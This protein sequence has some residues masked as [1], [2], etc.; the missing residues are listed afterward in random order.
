MRRLHGTEHLRR[1]RAGSRVQC[2]IVFEEQSNSFLPRLGGCVQQLL[3]D[4]GTVG[5]GIIQPPEIKAAQAFCAKGF[6]HFNSAFQDF[7]LLGEREIRFEIVRFAVL[8]AR[9][10]GPV[11]LKQRTRD[12]GDAQLV[13]FENALR[14]LNLRGIQVHDVLVPHTTQLDPLHTKL[15]GGHFAGTAEILGNLVVDYADPEWRC[16]SM[17]SRFRKRR[18]QNQCGCG[19]AA[20]LS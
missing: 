17:S 20:H 11:R 9:S 19:C 2:G 8:R 4:R 16:W 10:S 14:F 12:V 3:I 1:F 13:F 7:V 6:G 18:I 15:A 5:S